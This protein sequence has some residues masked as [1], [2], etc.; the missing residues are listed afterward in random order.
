VYHLNYDLEGEEAEPDARPSG[1]AMLGATTC[2][3]GTSGT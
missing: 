1:L 2:C 3:G